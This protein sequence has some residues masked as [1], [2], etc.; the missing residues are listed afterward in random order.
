MSLGEQLDQDLR[1]AMKARDEVRVGALR[2]LK[3]DLRNLEVARTDRGKESSPNPDFGK[4]VTDED[5]YRLIRKR[6][7]MFRESAD[8]FQ[9]AGRLESARHEEA[10]AAILGA[11]LPRQLSREEIA[12]HVQ[13]LVARN[14]KNFNLVIKQAMADLR[15]RADGKLINQVV[16]EQ[17]G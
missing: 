9:Q 6:L 17:T 1:V 10:E 8:M 3:T 14:G 2:L 4:P 16:R 7:Q 15:D 11:Y 13:E 5:V 12:A